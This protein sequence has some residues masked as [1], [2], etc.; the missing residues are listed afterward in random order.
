MA[1]E[2]YKISDLEDALHIAGIEYK[3]KAGESVYT[4]DEYY[5]TLPLMLQGD[6][7]V[8]L[9]RQNDKYSVASIE[10]PKYDRLG[11]LDAIA[12]KV[13]EEKG[14]QV[15]RGTRETTHSNGIQ[16]T[17]LFYLE[18]REPERVVEGIQ[19]IKSANE[20]YLRGKKRHDIFVA[21]FLRN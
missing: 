2:L 19:T 7:T 13:A 6:I 9:S 20:L 5:P 11:F 12:A 10:T 21:G 18:K 1:E 14:V 3:K 4:P 16:P 15:R 17:Q 8:R